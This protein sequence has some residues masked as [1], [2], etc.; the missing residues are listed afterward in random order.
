[1]Y[2]SHV[3]NYKVKNVKLK[4][5]LINAVYNYTELVY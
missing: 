4:A 3:A 5:L 1:M 2:L